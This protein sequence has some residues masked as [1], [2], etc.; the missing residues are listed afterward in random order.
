MPAQ[1]DDPGY[2]SAPD[3]LP[4]AACRRERPALVPRTETRV[5]ERIPEEEGSS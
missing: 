2:P 4:C 5:Q 3:A 1:A